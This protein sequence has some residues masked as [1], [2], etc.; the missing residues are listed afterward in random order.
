V[1]IFLLNRLFPT[2]LSSLSLCDEIWVPARDRQ[3]GSLGNAPKAELTLVG[4]EFAL[5]IVCVSLFAIR[6]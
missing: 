3:N 2:K 5:N 4:P 6:F 1:F